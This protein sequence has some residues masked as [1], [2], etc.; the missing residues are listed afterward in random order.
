[1]LVPAFYG[2][3]EH[4]DPSIEIFLRHEK[5]DACCGAHSL[6]E[7]YSVLTG[8]SGKE[9]VGPDEAMLFLGNIRERLT[10][11]A[12][13]DEEY[14][15]CVETSTVLGI[16]G[17]MIY[18]AVLARCALKSQAETIYTWN[19]KHW[20]RLGPEIASRLRSPENPPAL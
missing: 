18:D 12:L 14:F 2:D 9:R 5:P 8:M 3:H 16:R 4:H 10:I 11:I 17:G 19:I 7:V 1:M 15:E 20:K 6:A 13:T